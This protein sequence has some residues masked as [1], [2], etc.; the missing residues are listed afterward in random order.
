M[1]LSRLMLIP[2]A[3]QDGFVAC[4]RAWDTD[5]HGFYGFSRIKTCFHGGSPKKAL[6]RRGGP[7]G[8]LYNFTALCIRSG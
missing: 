4:N 1:A 2:E 3:I 5:S 7:A 8:R 6:C